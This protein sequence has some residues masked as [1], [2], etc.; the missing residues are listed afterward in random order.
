MFSTTLAVVSFIVTI[1]STILAIIQT[2]R[3]RSAKRIIDTHTRAILLESRDLASHLFNE[4]NGNVHMLQCGEKAQQIQKALW[5]LV[6]NMSNITEEEVDKKLEL[7]E[8]GE[9]EYRLLKDLTKRI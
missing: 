5:L 8:I 9:Y 7:K 2:L 6:I 4:A 3:L 1:A